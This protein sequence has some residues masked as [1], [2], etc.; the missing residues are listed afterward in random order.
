MSVMDPRD[1]TDTQ[2]GTKLRDAAVDPSAGD[3]LAPTNAGEVGELGNPHG[4][5]VVSPEIHG[6]EGVRPIRP[7]DVSGV[8]AT[9]DAAEHEHLATWQPETV[10]PE[11]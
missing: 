4:P 2:V 9:Q 11:V 7:G 1:V 3:F 10:P 5:S 8:A 6:S